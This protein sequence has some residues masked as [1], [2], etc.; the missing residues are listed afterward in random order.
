MELS[1][2]VEGMIIK[3]ADQDFTECNQTKLVKRLS[4]QSVSHSAHCSQSVSQIT[5]HLLTT[6]LPLGHT[7]QLMRA[8]RAQ[9]HT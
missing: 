2:N 8:H 7:A 9:S 5:K 1:D 4:S 3:N 6:F